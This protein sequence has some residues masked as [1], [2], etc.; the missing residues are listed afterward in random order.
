MLETYDQE[1]PHHEFTLGEHLVRTKEY[2]KSLYFSNDAPVYLAAL[3]HDISKPACK[4]Y[5]EEGYATY[6][7]HQYASAYDSLFYLKCMAYDTISDEKILEIC[8]L[9]QWHMYFF[10]CKADRTKL[11]FI[12]MVGVKT[13]ELLRI[14]HIA[15]MASS[16]EDSKEQNVYI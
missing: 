15:D 11:R 9:I 6:Y 3:L 14:L 10:D 4:E 5:N 7:G 16:R 13:Y 1:N 12:K 2:V 8:N